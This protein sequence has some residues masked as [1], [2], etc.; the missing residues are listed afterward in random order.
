M[1]DSQQISGFVISKCCT[2][3]FIAFS[4]RVFDG[5]VYRTTKRH[6][7]YAVMVVRDCVQ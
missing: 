4:D 6:A 7:L 1:L 5:C 3:K 2:G